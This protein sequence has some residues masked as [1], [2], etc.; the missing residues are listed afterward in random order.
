MSRNQTQEGEDS[1]KVSEKVSKEDR[2]KRIGKRKGPK[3]EVPVF[4]QTMYSMIE[5]D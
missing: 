4:L 1:V 5:G 2:K 3:S